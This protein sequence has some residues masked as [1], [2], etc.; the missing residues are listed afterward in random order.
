MFRLGN[1]KSTP[2]RAVVFDIAWRFY[3]NA[4]L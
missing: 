1:N 2:H 4:A 3:C